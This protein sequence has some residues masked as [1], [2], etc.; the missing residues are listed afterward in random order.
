MAR[1]SVFVG[2]SLDR[3]A[4]PDG[5]NSCRINSDL[6]VTIGGSA[7]CEPCLLTIPVLSFCAL[8]S[9]AIMA[10]NC[11]AKLGNFAHNTSKTA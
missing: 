8:I 11:G 7:C 2:L 10:L 5:K 1:N 3:I 9:H 4:S 6:R